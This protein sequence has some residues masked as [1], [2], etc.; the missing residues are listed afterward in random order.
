[1]ELEPLTLFE[2]IVVI[3]IF[4]VIFLNGSKLHREAQPCN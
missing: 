2:I 3:F 1:M 4:V